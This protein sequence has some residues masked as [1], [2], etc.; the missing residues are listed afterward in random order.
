MSTLLLTAPQTPHVT[1]FAADLRVEQ[2]GNAA[3]VEVLTFLQR[4]PLHTAYLAGLISDHGLESNLNRG[5]FYGC[6][7][8]L[9]QLEGVGLIGHA[10]LME[11]VSDRALRALAEK[12]QS[13]GRANLIMCEEDQ[14]DKFWGH[15][16]AAGQELRRACRELLFELRWPIEVSENDSRL[17][18]ATLDDLELL[19]PVHAEMAFTESGIDPRTKDATGFVSRYRR[20]IERGRTWILIEDQKLIFK[21][22]V[23]AE[24]PDSAYV[25]GVWLNPEDRGR[26][27]GRA[28]MAQ[29]ARMLLWRSKSICLFVNDENEQGRRFYRNA[30]YYHRATYDTFFLN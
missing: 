17:R 15:Y 14:I 12:A 2:L 26:G 21:A 5:T 22:D 9:G 7:N 16:A 29:L 11:T 8:Y 18:L 25:E 4:R 30:G 19:V 10:I 23:I 6:R 24:T 1:A 20:R 3:R 28:C 27:L 13:C